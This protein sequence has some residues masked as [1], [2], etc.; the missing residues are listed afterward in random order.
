MSKSS[1]ESLFGITL[2]ELV[3]ILFFIMLLLSIFNIDELQEE[4]SE[5]TLLVPESEE[6][7][8]SASAVVELLIP[9][10]EIDSDLIPL[11]VIREEIQKLQEDKKELEDMKS[12]AEGEG[13]GDCK[14]G[15]NWI[16]SKCADYCWAVDAEENKRQYDLLLDVGMC[17][18]FMVVQRSTWVNYT[19]SE[20]SLVPGALEAADQKI[21]TQKE[22][23]AY[24]DTIKQP[25][26]E[27]EPKQC[28]HVIRLVSLEPIFANPWNINQLNIQERVSTENYT[29]DKAGYQA[30]RNRFPEDICAV[31]VPNNTP[32]K[33]KPVN[34]PEKAE[35]ITSKINTA[36]N[37]ELINVKKAALVSSSFARE[38]INHRSCRR[39][40]SSELQLLFTVELDRLGNPGEIKLVSSR[41]GFSRSQDRLA[42]IATDALMRSNYTPE[43]V[44]DIAVPSLLEKPIKIEANACYGD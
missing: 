26:Y 6:D 8:V 44:E 10:G 23:Y 15:G 3:I 5:L 32:T 38:F 18:N 40:R 19:E 11:D 34:Q 14:E 30:V 31:Q 24:L 7:I 27:R 39:I 17:N 2:T 25:G 43:Y 37:S 21:M 36:S 42:N 16:N 35:A 12:L 1:K 29:E 22:L 41:E 28:F 20:F 4:V 9:E 13:D 33:I